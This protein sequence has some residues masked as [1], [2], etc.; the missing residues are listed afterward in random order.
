[1]PA[2]GVPAT[3][4]NTTEISAASAACGNAGGIKLN[5]SVMPFILRAVKLWGIDSVGVSLKRREFVW[6]QVLNLIDF[7]I[8][9][10]TVKV[11]SMKE[12]LD[13]FPKILKGEI[14]GR[15]VVD[16]NK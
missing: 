11:V 10:E 8:L 14:S 4:L 5:T 16:V 9:N 13:I 3:M 7:N 12:L 6:S 1:M 15:V 2:G